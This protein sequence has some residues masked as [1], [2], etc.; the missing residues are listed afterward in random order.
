[1]YNLIETTFWSLILVLVALLGV[2]V[3]NMSRMFLF[4]VEKY[5]GEIMYIVHV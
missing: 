5:F 2:L 3:M 4:L 1:M